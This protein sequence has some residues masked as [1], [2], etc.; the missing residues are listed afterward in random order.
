MVALGN[1]LIVGGGIAGMTLAI[2][3]KRV[4]IRS[5][6]VELNPQWTAVGTGI[7][8]QGPALRALRVVGVLDQC[9][10]AGFGYSQ[11]KACDADGRVTGTVELPHLNGPAYPAT[12]GIMRPAL[13]S[14]LQEALAKAQVTVRAG[15]TV[16]SLRQNADGVAVQ[17]NDDAR[18]TYD[19]VV[20]AD[21]ANSIVRDLVFGAACRPQYTGQAIWRATVRRPP[22]VKARHSY[23]G[24]RNKAGFNPVSDAAMYV[25]LVQNM[26]EFVR[27]PDERLPGA[28]PE[29]LADF[30]GTLAAVREDI[31]DPAHITHRPI[32]SHILPPPWHRGRVVLVGDAAHTTTPHMASGAGI[33]L[34][35]AVVL[36]ELLHAEENLPRALEKFMTRRYERCR[37]VVENSRQLG[38]WEKNPNA[39][40]ADVVRVMTTTLEAMA[41]PI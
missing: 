16:A 3:L 4:G 31:R 24:P 12:I 8:L 7:S 36:A 40:D 9:V 38:E 27:L 41:Q 30:G 39:A 1:I 19:L 18:G 33:A 25:Y 11:F 34:E 2:E 22:D 29:E 26:P 5:E 6:I 28:A 35:D 13:H 20:G 32:M 10:R 15:I 17:F 14:I 37:M 21:G 23:F